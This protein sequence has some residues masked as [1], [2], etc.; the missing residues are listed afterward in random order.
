MSYDDYMYSVA[1]VSGVVGH[2]STC[3]YAQSGEYNDD[4]M[5]TDITSNNT[6]MQ[7]F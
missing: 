2:M 7:V 4:I 5:H 3:C 1:F 6:F